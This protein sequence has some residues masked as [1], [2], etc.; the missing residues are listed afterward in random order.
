VNPLTAVHPS[1][2]SGS[3]AAESANSERPV[4]RLTRETTRA[5]ALRGEPDLTLRRGR[6]E[7]LDSILGEFDLD[8]EL[9]QQ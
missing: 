8:L 4:E 5:C 6:R 2:G 7:R 9:G 1:T 3:D